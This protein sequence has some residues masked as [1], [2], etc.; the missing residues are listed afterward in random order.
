MK[1]N[2]LESSVYGSGSTFETYN[3]AFQWLEDRKAS[4]YDK[5][6]DRTYAETFIGGGHHRSYD[7]SHTF[8][9]SYDA[10]HEATGD[11]DLRQFL[12]AHFDEL[13]TPNGIPMFTLDHARYKTLTNEISEI[14]G[15]H[16]SAGALRNMGL[17][18]NSINAGE[19]ATAGVGSIFL[20]AAFRSGNPQAISRV[21]ALNLCVGLCTGN[22]VQVVTG[23]GGLALGVY[24]GKIQSW[25]LLMGA[26]PPLAGFG[27]SGG[28]EFVGAGAGTSILIGLASAIAT[29]A[30]LANLDRKRQARLHYELGGN[31]HY[32]AA[33]SPYGIGMQLGLWERQQLKL[34]VSI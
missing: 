19:L 3:K 34:A 20:A 13:V 18:F 26:A 28:A 5:I 31:T 7:G 1:K 32:L 25:D 24:L 2:I 10:I 15:G 29:G 23:L 14:L 9:G 11:V 21:T 30:Y 4:D 16:V 33:Q 6:M 12:E 8:S 27:M 17:D 22:P